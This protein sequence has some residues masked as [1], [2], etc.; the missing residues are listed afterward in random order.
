MIQILKKITYYV[1]S[2]FIFIEFAFWKYSIQADVIPKT[3]L[4]TWNTSLTLSDIFVWA[5]REI[6]SIIIFI[7]VVVFIF[8][9]VR[10]A[11]ARWNPE[12]F[13]KS[14]IHFVYAI[15]GLFLVFASIGIVRLIS[16]LWNN[17]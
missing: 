9:G 17:F 13:K 1:V 14:W 8:I 6:F 7:A 3:D 12:E 11:S 16:N 2:L 4:P 10:M 15:I 5:S